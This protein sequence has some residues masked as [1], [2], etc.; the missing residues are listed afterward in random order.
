MTTLTNIAQN[1]FINHDIM[2]MKLLGNPGSGKTHAIIQF[3]IDKYTKKIVNSSKN[4]LIISFSRK[5]KD[6]FIS[7]GRKSSKPK[8]FN[9]IMTIHKLASIIFKNCYSK[10]STN[11]NTIILATYLKIIENI[12]DLTQIK[13]LSKCK[14]IIIDEA[15]DISENQYNFISILSNKLNIPLILVGDPN[16]SI[17]Q[18]QGGSDKFLLNHPGPSI[19]LTKNYRSTNQIIAFLNKLRPWN[20]LPS[21]ESANNING[22]KPSIYVESIDNILANMLVE[23]KT[24]E[25]SDIAI[26]GPVKKANFKGNFYT[27]I[28]LQLI[29]NFLEK[30]NIKYIQHYKLDDIID[31]SQYEMKKDHVN[32]IT[33]HGSK[34]LEFK[35]TL[36]INFHQSTFGI[37]PTKEDYNHF[38]YLWYVSLS[39]AKEEL[40]IYVDNNKKIFS[41][42]IKVD[43]DLY[44]LTGTLDYQDSYQDEIKPDKYEVTKIINDNKYFN[45]NILYEFEKE[46]T[47]QV[48]KEKLF[49]CLNSDLEEHSLFSSLYGKFMEELLTVYYHYNDI[50]KYI[51]SKKEKLN[52]TIIITTDNFNIYSRLQSKGFIIDF[53]LY[54]INKILDNKDCVDSDEYYFIKECYDKVKQ[55]T[56]RMFKESNLYYYDNK[57]I[58]DL[59]DDLLSKDIPKTVFNIILYWYQIENEAMYLMKKDFTPHLLSLEK[60]F[61]LLNKLSKNMSPNLLFQQLTTH[62]HYNLVGIIDIIDNNKIIELKF[63]KSVDIKH[64]IQTLLYSNNYNNF[65]VKQQTSFEIWNLYDGTKYIVTFDKLTSW[66][67]NCFICKILNITMY[68]NVFIFDLETNMIDE[69][70]FLAID[71]MEIIERYVYEYNFKCEVSNG[72]IKPTTIL[73]QSIIDITHITNDMLDFA[74]KDITKFKMELELIMK[75]CYKP[76]FIA[77]NGKQFDFKILF[78]QNLLDKKRIRMIDTRY[79][80]RLIKPE[81]TSGKLSDMYLQICNKVIKNAHR[82]KA[83]TKMIVAII[84]KLKITTDMLICM[85]DD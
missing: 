43:K 33:A 75:Y 1:E 11:V 53:V 79:D 3:C 2:N 23:L 76:I 58:S 51:I 70:N 78:S 13:L 25:L 85:S 22:P 36:V 19:S 9:N 72:L 68:N 67:L 59:Y 74:D 83:D 49:D 5:A 50:D 10:T 17:Y 8:I 4:F 12:I 16:Q 30:N 32:L 56:I 18:F 24:H 60:Y 27:N 62:N 39:R 35:K 26:I 77:H 69:N 41:E 81:L 55:N 57:Y 84:N 47:Y 52:N 31:T 82:A 40:V 63:V 42:I 64:I 34:G 6:D 71:N 21:M 28:G 61:D 38:K 65:F 80:L 44:N 46:F 73:K 66:K 14:M 37:K 48:E 20:T 15:Q 54:D 45:E 7:K 29:A